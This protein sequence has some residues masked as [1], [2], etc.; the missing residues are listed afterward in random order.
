MYILL[1]KEGD[2][3]CQLLTLRT[4]NLGEQM[5]GG[6]TKRGERQGEWWLVGRTILGSLIDEK[7]CT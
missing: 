2:E 3:E 6:T 7:G 1:A 5:E 4:N